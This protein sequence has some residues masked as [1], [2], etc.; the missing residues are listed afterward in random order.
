[1][2]PI[3]NIKLA[4]GIPCSFPFVPFSFFQSFLMV[5]RPDYTLI[6]KTNGPIDTLRNDIVKK[7]LDIGSTHL[8]MCDVDQVY[9]VHTVTRLLSH[10]LPVV[11]ASVS[12]RYPP[13]DKII[14]RINKDTNSYDSV[15]DWKDGELLE[16]DA[17]GTGCILYQMDVFKKIPEPW[18][19]FVT[20]DETGMTIGEDIYLCQKIKNAGYKIFV[21][22][23]VEVGHLTTMVVNQ[24]THDLYKSMKCAQQQ[25][26]KAMGIF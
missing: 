20:D 2:K 1:M 5:D 4:I 17:T 22:T 14:L 23:S 11:G 24:K 18:F 19:E 3:S 13:F 16:C 8:L 7:A 9:P 25:K 12:R 15:D 6:T 10:G 21:D 26:N